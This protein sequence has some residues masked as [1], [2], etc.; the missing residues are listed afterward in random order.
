[1]G[2]GDPL[3]GLV[4]HPPGADDRLQPRPQAPRGD[5]LEALALQSGHGSPGP[6]SNPRRGGAL[7]SPCP[8]APGGSRAPTRIS[9]A[10]AEGQRMICGISPP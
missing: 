4:E 5:R 7:H 6:R 10:G 8:L 1:V 2:V 3:G 9:C